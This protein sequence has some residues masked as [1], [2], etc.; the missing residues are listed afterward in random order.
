[1]T[2]PRHEMVRA[3][4]QARGIHDPRVLDAM[5]DVKRHLFVPSESFEDAYEDFPLPIGEGQTISQP[6]IVALMTELLDAK[7]ADRVLE[8]GTGCGYQTAVLSRLV[9]DVYSIEIVKALSERAAEQ[10]EAQG[11]SNT[12]LRVGD[13]Y[14]GWPEYAPFDGIIVTAAPPERGPRSGHPL[15]KI[16]SAG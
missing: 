4:I 12:H 13:G 16:F 15:V 14:N 2:E 5:R 3:Q 8:I 9:A 6:Y 7:P 11:F 10:L 1:M